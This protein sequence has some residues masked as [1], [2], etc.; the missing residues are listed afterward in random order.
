MNIVDAYIKYNK[1]LL[2]LISGLSGTSKSKVGK[3][4]SDKF[5]I[6]F[7]DT[8]RFMTEP[9][10]IETHG[11][12]IKSWIKSYD[13][14]EIKNEI[15]KHVQNGVVVCGEYFAEETMKD[16]NVDFHI[17][18]KLSK[19]NLIKQ[20]TK[21]IETNYNK[22]P[23]SKPESRSE[24]D[25]EEKSEDNSEEKSEDNSEEKSEDNSEEKSEDNSE[26]KSEDNSEEKSEEK[27]EESN[28]VSDDIILLNQVVYPFYIDIIQKSKINKFIN[29]NEILEKSNNEDTYVD[30]VFGIVFDTL[31]EFIMDYFK[32]KDMDKYI[33]KK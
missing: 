21:F 25:P 14:E 31:I 11:R 16:L 30:E 27:S 5:K 10:T 3:L 7:I 19:Q 4:I 6:K 2:I 23:K 18:I 24:N 33:E 15:R 1:Q 8:R 32:K 20:R 22:K 12:K 17:H 9:E 13:Y 28:E 26:E 29:A